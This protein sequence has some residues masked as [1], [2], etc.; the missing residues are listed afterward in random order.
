MEKS[1]YSEGYATFLD[2]LRAERESRGL[3]QQGLAS[4]LGTTQTR[5][6]KCERGERRLDVLELYAWCN[7]IGIS[8]SEFV[9]RLE[10]ALQASTTGS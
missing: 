10:E 6:S 5:V 4:R 1:I 2:L 3:T 7:A 8:T 9:K